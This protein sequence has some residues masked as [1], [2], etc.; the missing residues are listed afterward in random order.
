MQIKG[1][2]GPEDHGRGHTTL[3]N[4]RLGVDRELPDVPQ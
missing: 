3:G 1:E 4:E 2:G